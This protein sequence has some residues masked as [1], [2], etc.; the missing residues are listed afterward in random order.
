M[1]SEIFVSNKALLSHQDNRYVDHRM[2]N[3]LDHTQGGEVEYAPEVLF[4]NTL[5]FQS[6]IKGCPGTE[7]M[8]LPRAAPMR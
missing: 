3:T 8:R 5:P 4:H 7:Y 2:Q 6:R 1:I